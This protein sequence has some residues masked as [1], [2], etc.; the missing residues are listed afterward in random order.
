MTLRR[1][2]HF[3]TLAASALLIA[4]VPTS[5]LAQPLSGAAAPTTSPAPAP[6]PATAPASATA[7]TTATASD[8]AAQLTPQQSVQRDLDILKAAL[9]GADSPASARE[10]AAQKLLSRRSPETHQ[11]LVDALM[12]ST[13]GLLAAVNALAEDPTPDSRLSASLFGLLL[14]NR[15]RQHSEAAARALSRYASEPLVLS[16]LMALARKSP[17]VQEQIR[18]EVIRSL[19]YVIEKESAATLMNVL[20]APEETSTIRDAAAEALAEMSSHSD[21]GQDMLKWEQWWTPLLRRNEAEFRADLLAARSARLDQVQRQ[22]IEMRDETERFLTGQ[23]NAAAPDRRLG[24]LRSYLSSTA[25]EIRRIGVRIISIGAASG[26]PVA[27][28]VREQLRAMI[29]DSDR[30]VR[31]EV[32]RG[33]YAIN[34]RDA[35]AGL[36]A[37]L[38]QETDPAVRAA[39][40]E[41]L[42]PINNLQAVRP[43]L[44]LVQGTSPTAARAAARALRSLGPKLI[45]DDREL[46][47]KAAFILRSSLEA[48]PANPANALLRES[49]IEAMREL[50]DPSLLPTYYSLLRDES[51]ET[52]RLALRAI[53]DIGRAESTNSVASFIDDRESRVRA[54]ALEALA[55]LPGANGYTPQLIRHMDKAQEP[56][57]SVRDASWRT[58]IAV[59]KDLNVEQLQAIVDDRLFR[60]NP[61]NQFQVYKVLET[62]LAE[63]VDRQN[64]LANTQMTIGETLMKLKRW[65]EAADYFG[66]ALAAK[67]AQPGTSNLVLISLVE[68]RMKALLQAAKF[69]EAVT[70]AA[71]SIRENPESQQ[72]LGA[73]IRQRAE[74]LRV[75]GKFEEASR[76]ISAALQM[77]PPLAQQ[78]RDQ[79]NETERL[80]QTRKRE[81]GKGTPPIPRNV[82]NPSD[83]PAAPSTRTASVDE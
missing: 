69:A 81:Q 79:L 5:A 78:Y 7:P 62:K 67:K 66:K 45:A 17:P 11:I 43:L 41:A 64:D 25:S 44:E 59:L 6:A 71:S 10:A 58:L 15:S 50:R 73:A 39:L 54:A 2:T 20:R 24:I 37:Q 23:Y 52:R 8:V 47:S 70:F 12:N 51:I 36:L 48:L 32:A 49:F 26:D 75:E 63:S 46:A 34:D 16:R 68:N 28:P 77:D 29:G 57:E 80:I 3:L 65:D 19:G 82:I 18:R 40:A 1:G 22:R 60:E 61:T 53:G 56:E 27:E 30:D 42:G 21:F 31:M 35:L 76:L 72:P 55:N 14:E 38:T 4:V 83:R 74:E 13:P 33:L 9:N